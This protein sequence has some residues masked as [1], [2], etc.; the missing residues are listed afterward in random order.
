MSFPLYTEELFFLSSAALLCPERQSSQML[1]DMQINQ[2]GGLQLV[3]S[4]SILRRHLRTAAM[5]LFSTKS[6]AELTLCHDN[7]QHSRGHGIFGIAAYS[8]NIS[9]EVGCLLFFPSLPFFS[10]KETSIMNPCV[11]NLCC[12]S[13]IRLI[14]HNMAIIFCFFIKKPVLLT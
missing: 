4:S 11:N 8:L 14:V 1:S 5:A 12:S 6:P 9:R 13:I 10:N 2:E 7:L 3:A